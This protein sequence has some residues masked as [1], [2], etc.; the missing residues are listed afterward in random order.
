VPFAIDANALEFHFPPLDFSAN[1]GSFCVGNIESE[2]E[3]TQSFCVSGASLRVQGRRIR[4]ERD[5]NMM[6]KIHGKQ[7]TQS[8]AIFTTALRKSADGWRIA[9]WAWAKGTS[10]L[11]H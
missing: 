4:L 11:S 9:A 10:V 2:P 3:V 6:F 5:A 7:V 8:G 1:R